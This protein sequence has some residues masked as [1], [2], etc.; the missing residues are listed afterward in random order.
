M[1]AVLPYHQKHYLHYPYCGKLL[2]MLISITIFSKTA[3][4]PC[5][6]ILDWSRRH[7]FLNIK[8]EENVASILISF[9]FI[10]QYLSMQ[11]YQ[12]D[13]GLHI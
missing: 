13:T 10:Q 9:D 3:E 2:S 7:G 11:H 4:K 8:F 5:L 6:A 12:N 1:Y